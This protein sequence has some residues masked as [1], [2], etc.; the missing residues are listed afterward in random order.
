VATPP[1]QRGT[2]DRGT[3]ARG[4]NS[5]AAPK[6]KAPEKAPSPELE[7]IDSCC[8]EFI[9]VNPESSN[10]R[11]GSG[12]HRVIREQLR[13]HLFKQGFGPPLKIRLP[14]ASFGHYRGGNGLVIGN[15]GSGNGDVD[16]AV[17]SRNG[18]EMLLAE[19]KPANWEALTGETQLANYVD[20][21]N[22]NEDIKRRWNVL[23]FSRM[24]PLDVTLPTEVIHLSGR[25][26]IRWCGPGLVLYKRIRTK[27]EEE[28]EE[29]ERKIKEALKSRY[30][31]AAKPKSAVDQALRSAARKLEFQD[32]VP[33]ALRNDMRA[34]NLPDGLYRNRYQAAW[35]SGYTSNV[36]LW[37]KS[38]PFGREYQYYQEFPS[39]P[40]FYEYLARKKGLSE[41]QR[42]LVRATL[43]EYNND[44][45][46]L[47][48]PNRETGAPSSMSPYYARDE[49]R[50]IYAEVLKG[51]VGGSA[52]I[53]ASGAAITGIANAMRQR[54]TQ[55]R[56]VEDRSLGKE[57]AQGT[58]EEPL[59]DWV[60]KAV[61]SAQK[62]PMPAWM[63]AIESGFEA[64]R[65]L[66][67]KGVI[68]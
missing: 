11:T 61:E 58:K 21:A 40:A 46:S 55:G 64:A 3:Q 13:D 32:W 42:E 31:K 62:E 23:V 5:G 47:I 15:K 26:E 16:L 2:G 24:R 22:A 20:K 28:Q 41:W 57:D 8:R 48:S 18:A 38:G 6:A 63:K 56:G 45:W 30:G 54:M 52:R 29:K 12:V 43:V 17:R 66:L 39:D 35:P 60:M 44:L 67:P 34:N 65:Q 4:T 51:V 10:T 68:P 50:T 49:L 9:T 19:I 53:V 1:E 37:L 36:V 25:F 14:D 59:P 7:P 33:E 27:E